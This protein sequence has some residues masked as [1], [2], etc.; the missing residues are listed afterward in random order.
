MTA[1]TLERPDKVQLRTILIGLMLVLG[2]G[3]AWTQAEVALPTSP[4]VITGL[5]P[6]ATRLLPA[7]VNVSTSETINPM[8]KKVSGKFDRTK[9][10]AAEMKSAMTVDA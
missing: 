3:S 7:V 9:V 4:L 5:G 2:F 10:M 8:T 6:L 1:Q